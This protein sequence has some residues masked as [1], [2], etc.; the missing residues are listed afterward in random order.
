MRR[1][2]VLPG[3]VR[4]HQVTLGPRI[5]RSETAGIATAALVLHAL[6]ELGG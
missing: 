1:F 6:G 2:F 3:S 4:G 5:L